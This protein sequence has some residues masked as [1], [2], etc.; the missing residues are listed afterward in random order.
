MTR[1]PRP[2]WRLLEQTAAGDAGAWEELRDR[3]SLALYAQ[4]FALVG[5]PAETEEVVTDTLHEAW[6]SAGQFD[7]SGDITASAWL[8]GLAR[9]V[10]LARRARLAGAAGATP[11]APRVGG[12]AA[13][14]HSVA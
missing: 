4:V 7:L 2:D 10:V 3:Y 13:P 1:P 6:C 11:A 14:A 5:T 9:G 12:G 8:V